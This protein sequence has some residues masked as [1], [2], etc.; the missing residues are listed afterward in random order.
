MKVKVMTKILPYV[1]LYYAAAIFCLWSGAAAMEGGGALEWRA[2]TSFDRSADATAV[3]SSSNGRH[4]PIVFANETHA[5]LWGGTTSTA[6]AANDFYL[7]D[8]ATDAWTELTAPSSSSSADA[9][10]F[11]PARS[12][13]YG[14]VLNELY[15]PKAYI[16]FGADGDGI[17][18][19]DL[20]EFDMTTL[21][22]RALA[23]CPCRGRNHPSMV[24]VYNN[25]QWTIHMGL[26]DSYDDNGK[27]TNLNDYWSYD[28]DSDTWQPLPDFPSS[29]RHHPFYFPLHGASYV[30]LGHSDGNNP[31]I[32]RDFYSYHVANNNTWRREPDFASYGYLDDQSSS[33]ALTAGV[34]ATG[35]V[36]TTTEARVA[37]TQF[38][39]ELPLVGADGPP[40]N[41][42]PGSIGFVLSGDGDDHGYMPTGEFHAFYPAATTT[43]IN[44]TTSNNDT[45]W[46]RQ[47]TPHPGG[48][49]WAPGSFV[50]RNTATAYFCCGYD[51][52]TGM[53]HSDVWSIDLSS[54]F[55]SSIQPPTPPPPAPAP[56]DNNNNNNGNDNGAADTATD[57]GFFGTSA[58]RTKHPM[59]AGT[60]MVLMV[61]GTV[62]GLFWT[63]Y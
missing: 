8:A 44:S 5:F 61:L 51:R 7:Y 20:W 17:P 63:H 42:R 33:S 49:R 52:A 15:H 19:N 18:L 48:A 16:G 58:A 55:S 9:D 50:L 39:I 21:A 23:A 38:S 59:A 32:E 13:A 3:T 60:V 4:H 54:L 27:F 31:Y 56:S 46:W 14:I 36:V 28:I 30:G 11:P 45:A 34:A 29:K 57:V 62:F 1:A 40:N 37:G 53:L 43:T 6:A 25:N 35:L 12:F 2:Q 10:A 47:L 26:G 41:L 24:S 22:W